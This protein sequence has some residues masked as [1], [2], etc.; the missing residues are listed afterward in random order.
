[1]HDVE[2]GK[3]KYEDNKS[4]H[5]RNILEK[6]DEDGI[7]IRGEAVQHPRGGAPQAVPEREAIDRGIKRDGSLCGLLDRMSIV[8]EREWGIG[9]ALDCAQVECAG[10]I[11]AEETEAMQVRC[12]AEDASPRKEE[13]AEGKGKRYDEG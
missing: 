2:R 5:S 10:G 3:H 11:Y 9:F 13:N 12:P 1:M 4:A 7:T 6:V 8:D